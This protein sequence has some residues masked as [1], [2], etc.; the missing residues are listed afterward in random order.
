[1][2]RFNPAFAFTLVPG[3]STVP[4]ADLEHSLDLQVFTFQ[5]IGLI[6]QSTAMLM[7]R[8]RSAVLL[9]SLPLGNPS[10]CP[11][12]STRPFLLSG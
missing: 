1:M 9:F 11:Q 8:I 10:L 5:R 4:L 6:G 2:T 12:G 7:C 3:F